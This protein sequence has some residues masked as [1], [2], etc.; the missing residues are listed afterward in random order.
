MEIPGF[1][2]TSALEQAGP[3]RPLAERA[4]RDEPLS[5]EQA[6]AVLSS[7]DADLPAVLWAAFAPRAHYFARRVKVC[8]LQNARSGLCPEDCG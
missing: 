7:P 6:L 1:D 3:Y 4:V 2:V 5:R 8:V